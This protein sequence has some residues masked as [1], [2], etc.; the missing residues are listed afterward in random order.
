MI[1]KE[2]L[3]IKEKINNSLGQLLTFNINQVSHL[4]I[5]KVNRE[6]SK[7]G[8]SLQVE[9]F[10]ILFLLAHSTEGSLSQQEIANFLQKDKSGIQ[11]SIRT[12]ERDGYLRVAADDNDRRK[13]VVQ[14]TPAGKLTIKKISEMAADIN[15][16]VTSQLTPEEVSTLLT[17]LKKIS[18]KMDS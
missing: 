2:Q 18:S 5:R 17:L 8:S 13:N 16:Q 1:T 9:Q 7:S 11:R 3:S 6:L 10:P 15:R 4:F 14:L 12:L